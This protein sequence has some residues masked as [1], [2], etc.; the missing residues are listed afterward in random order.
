MEVTYIEVQ[1]KSFDFTLAASDG[2]PTMVQINC[3]VNCEGCE[4]TFLPEAL[5]H[6]WIQQVPIIQMGWHLM[7][8]W[9]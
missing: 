6:G 9:E 3:H 8:R 4:W 5:K 1:I 7:E 2:I